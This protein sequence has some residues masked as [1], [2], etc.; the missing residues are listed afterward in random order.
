[1]IRDTAESDTQLVE[2]FVQQGVSMWDGKDLTVC[3]P[4]LDANAATALATLSV[5][6]T[7]L[8]GGVP[9]AE[10]EEAV[11]R[12]LPAQEA[13]PEEKAKPLNPIEELFASL[14]EKDQ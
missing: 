11:R 3:D 1:M 2:R 6:G 8:I 7:R 10:T 9:D 5:P 4:C 14:V 12:R 13:R